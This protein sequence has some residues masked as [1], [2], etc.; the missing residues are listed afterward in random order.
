MDVEVVLQHINKKGKIAMNISQLIEQFGGTKALDTVGKGIG[1]DR[2]QVESLIDS[3]APMMLRGLQH[4]TSTDEGLVNFLEA[5]QTGSH[6]RYLDDPSVLQSKEAKEDGW[7]ILGHIFGDQSANRNVAAEASNRTGIDLS[8]IEKALP[9]IAG[10][11][12][13][14]MSK[15]SNAG[16]EIATSRSHPNPLGSLASMFD[17]NQDGKVLDDIIGMASRDI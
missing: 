14:A 2:N 3:V 17:L 4:R 7:N 1:L 8:L 15:H 16:S 6:G 12:M 13:G 9:V 5:L 10:L 11:V